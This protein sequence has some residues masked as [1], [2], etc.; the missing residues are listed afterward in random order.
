MILVVCALPEELPG[1][2]PDERVELLACGIGPVEAAAAVARA[3]AVRR[4]HTVINAGIAGAFREHPSELRLGDACIVD[5]EIFAD[6]GWENA[7]DPALPDGAMLVRRVTSSPELLQRAGMLPYPIV[8]GLTSASVTTTRATE[9]RLF[10]THDAAVESME[11]FAVLRAAQSAGVPA[12]AVRGISNLVG[13]RKMSSWDFPAGSQAA[14]NALR[15]LLD[16][17]RRR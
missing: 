6:L 16:L 11:G 1:F 9:L 7:E 8:R 5:E 3:L 12:I 17:L 13:P 15:A 14:A 4:Y 10:G 2:I